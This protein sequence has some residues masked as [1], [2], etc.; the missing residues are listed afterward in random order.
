MEPTFDNLTA[1]ELF[2]LRGWQ[3][4]SVKGS[5]NLRTM[6][7]THAV[8]IFPANLPDLLEAEDEPMEQEEEED[9]GDL[10][11]QILGGLSG[12]SELQTMQVAATQPAPPP[13]IFE[14][15]EVQQLTSSTITDKYDTIRQSIIRA[16]QMRQ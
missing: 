6:K 12:L 7:D 1:A 4:H 15:E 5:D 2:W 10:L 8:T 11:T 3:P 14:V 16:L 13:E 9:V